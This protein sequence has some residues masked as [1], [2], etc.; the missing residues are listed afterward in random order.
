[1]LL[2]SH[3]IVSCCKAEHS[4]EHDQDD[5][6]TNK[7]WNMLCD[8]TKSTFGDRIVLH[9]KKLEQ[10]LIT[11]KSWTVQL[12]LKSTNHRMRPPP[13]YESGLACPVL[14]SPP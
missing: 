6:K 1:M 12:D 10:R 7:L 4:R 3:G 13:L 11:R 8:N 9:M 2:S 14:L 5:I